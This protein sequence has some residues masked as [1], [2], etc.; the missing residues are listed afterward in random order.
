MNISPLVSIVLNALVTAVSG[1]AATQVDVGGSKTAL[2]AVAATALI[3]GLLHAASSAVA[4][5]LAT[6][7]APTPPAATTP[8]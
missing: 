6:P 7:A 8:K 1:V 2:W 4:G 5:P 3:N